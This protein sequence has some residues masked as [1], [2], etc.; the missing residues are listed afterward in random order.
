MIHFVGALAFAVGLLPSVVFA[1]SA[2][3]PA[4][5]VRVIVPFPRAALQTLSPAW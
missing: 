2:A 4:K 5:P 1:Q 3:Y